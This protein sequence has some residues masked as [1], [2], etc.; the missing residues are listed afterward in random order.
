[1]AVCGSG[2][3]AST[4]QVVDPVLLTGQIIFAATG[5]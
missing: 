1:M 5:V 3:G 4:V 2:K